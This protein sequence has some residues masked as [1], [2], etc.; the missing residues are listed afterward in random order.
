M[1]N[2]ILVPIKRVY[3][4]HS[5]LDGL[6]VVFNRIKEKIFGV[7]LSVFDKTRQYY[8]E[9]KNIELSPEEAL[10]KALDKKSHKDAWF[11]KDRKKARD[12]LHFYKEVDTY[13]FRQPY[14]KRHGGLRWYVHLIDHIRDEK[15][16][17]CSILEYGCGSACLTEWLMKKFPESDYY[18]A[19]IP[20]T[21]LDFVKWKKKELKYPYTILTVMLGKKGIPL[22]EDYDLI[23][24][25]GV[26]EHTLNPLEIVESFC[27][28]LS[29][30][31]VLI[32][33][34]IDTVGGENLEASAK[35]RERVK[36]LLKRRLTTIKA[37]DEPKG[38]DGLY[39]RDI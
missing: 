19:D 26:L 33:D 32:L 3:R 8:K 30:K 1:D 16:G 31:G 18:V 2:D 34:F 14:L 20:S 15:S 11:T 22:K 13:P 12:I 35:Q 38:S 9:T 25:Q 10:A 28:H 29:P 39:L 7:D 17:K 5:V 6:E 21:T 37:I 4:Y 36:A 27:D 23:I 24:C